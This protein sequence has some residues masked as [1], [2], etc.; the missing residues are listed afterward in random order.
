MFFGTFL[1][2]NT[3][4][5]FFSY[6]S[7]RPSDYLFDLNYLGRSEDSG[8]LSQQVVITEGGFKSFFEDPYANQWILSSNASI[9]VWR[10]MELYADAGFLKNRNE[11]ARFKYDYRNQ[12]KFY[13]QFP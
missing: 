12:A 1:F 13:P 11:D 6:S 7:D 9:G 2:N 10:W 8:F 3:Q 5:D 4:S